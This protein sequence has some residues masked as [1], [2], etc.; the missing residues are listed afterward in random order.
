MVVAPLSTTERPEEELEDEVD[1]ATSRR[2]EPTGH[3]LPRM[4]GTP[5]EVGVRLEG[6]DS[7]EELDEDVRRKLRLASP[8][9]CEFTYHSAQRGG[10]TRRAFSLQCKRLSSSAPLEGCND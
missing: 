3:V 1:D 9:V 8:V 7:R 2:L 10:T 6:D 4:P 5:D